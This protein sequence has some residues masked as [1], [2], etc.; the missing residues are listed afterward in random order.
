MKLSY[1][2]VKRRWLEFR[3][4]Y[5]T[6]LIFVV[7]FSNFTLILY[8]LA[9][10]IKDNIDFI[11]FISIAVAV[12]LVLGILFGSN[13]LKR[14]YPVE[15]IVST[16][17]NPF[18]YRIIPDS[19]EAVMY[20]AQLDQLHAVAELLQEHIKDKNKREYHCKILNEDARLI[21][22]ILDGRNTKDMK[23]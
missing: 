10:S 7:G 20:K 14:Q 11:P 5:S 1:D 4:G 15:A 17:N 23:K 2:F 6:Y 22:G 9:P 12:I 18:T 21:E 13:H 8:G 3:T 19:K 16:E